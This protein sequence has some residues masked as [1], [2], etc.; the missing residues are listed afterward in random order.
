MAT[1]TLSAILLRMR[2][3][4]EAAAAAM[5]ESDDLDF[6]G[7]M[8]HVVRLEYD[9]RAVGQVYDVN[10]VGSF[11]GAH[12]GRPASWQAVV[13]YEEIACRVVIKGTAMIPNG[14]MRFG[15]VLFPQE[16]P[17]DQRNSLVYAETTVGTIRLYLTGAITDA[18]GMGHHW[19]CDFTDRPQ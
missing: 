3:T 9:A 12:P 14:S 8:I 6:I 7:G 19:L 13:G 18:H 16:I 10:A 1:P 2:Q 5:R 4:R 17:A 15:R 11:A